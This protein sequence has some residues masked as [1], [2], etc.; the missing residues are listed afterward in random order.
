MPATIVEFSQTGRR[1]DCKVLIDQNLSYRLTSRLTTLF[2]NVAHIKTLGLADADDAQIW[3]FAH[4]SGFIILT[5]DSDF[6]D[7]CELKGWPPKIIWLRCGNRSTTELLE[8]I[9]QSATAIQS[10]LADA[11]SGLMEIYK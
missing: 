2:T 11:S 9:Q 8:I 3:N 5:Q 1:I 7:L 6:N 4:E 10:F